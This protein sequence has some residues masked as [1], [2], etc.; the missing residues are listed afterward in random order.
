[1]SIIIT[2]LTETLFELNEISLGANV[3]SGD[4]EYA[5]EYFISFL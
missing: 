2:D 3:L 5:E 1:M 4:G